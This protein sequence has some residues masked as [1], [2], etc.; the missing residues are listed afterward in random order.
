MPL[1]L[2]VPVVDL[3]L[4]VAAGLLA[5]AATI[6]F[7]KP[8]V[9]LFSRIPVIGGQV[10]GA[11]GQAVGAIISWA[12]E[13]LG[14]GGQ[15]LTQV[16]AVPIEAVRHLAAEVATTAE[17][18]LAEIGRQ[19][20]IASGALGSV[21]DRL[22][23]LV[24]RVSGISSLLHT[25]RVV[26]A[27][28]V[29]RV[30]HLITVTLP[31][32]IEGVRTWARAAIANAV[33]ALHDIL[34]KAIAA[35]RPWVVAAIAV[36]L[37]PIQAAIDAIRPW[38]LAAI[39]VALRPFEAELNGLGKLIDGVRVGLGQLGGQLEKLLPLLALIPLVGIIVQ[40]IPRL[41]TKERECY[42]PACDYLGDVLQGLGA[43]GELLTGSVMLALVASAINDPEG[44]ANEVA[45]W[46]DELRPGASIISGV[47][48]GRPI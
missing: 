8:L 47:I 6:I 41:I 19:A 14:K 27:S 25:A 48:A 37:R 40:A 22:L 11:I 42:D 33:D 30:A 46:A 1:L 34:A 3:F 7:Q 28:L 26:L 38:V 20:R 10:A 43:A 4:A 21:A 31:A 5:W 9:E 12:A 29:D 15:A 24:G 18:L 45:G 39:A 32:A 23:D 2:A 44:T 13:W 16:L 35:I 36:A 17:S